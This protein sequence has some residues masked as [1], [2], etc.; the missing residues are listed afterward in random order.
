MEVF[1][2]ILGSDGLGG[3]GSLLEGPRIL[4]ND[5]GLLVRSGFCMGCKQRIRNRRYY[6]H[7]SIAAL[8]WTVAGLEES[9]SEEGSAREQATG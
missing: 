7:L 2:T 1:L 3:D 5:I 8:S 9:R 4:A 6:E